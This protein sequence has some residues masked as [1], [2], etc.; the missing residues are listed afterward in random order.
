MGLLPRRSRPLVLV[1]LLL[2]MLA[3]AVAHVSA[4]EAAVELD[5][6]DDDDG[7]PAGD[8]AYGV[9]TFESLDDDAVDSILLGGAAA[10]HLKMTV[11]YCVS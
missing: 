3:A 7:A 10:E 5:G 2:C 6:F 4:A 9:D 1:I 8:D 11:Q